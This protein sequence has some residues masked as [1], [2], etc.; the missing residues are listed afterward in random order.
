MIVCPSCGANLK[1]DPKSQK[2]LCDFCGSSFDPKEFDVKEDAQEQV[3]QEENPDTPEF[4]TIDVTIYTCPQCGGELM[5]VDENTAAAFC[6]FCG[7]STILNARLA[8][9]KKPEYIIPFAKTKEDC[10]KAYL[11]VVGK[12]LFLPKEYRSDNCIDSFR[13]I[14]MPYW[15]Y[16][17]KQKGQTKLRGETSHRRGD[18]I[19]TDI[20]TLAGKIDA[21]YD[22]LSFDASASF[23]DSMSE[24]LAPYDIKQMVPFEASY[25]SGYYADLADVDAD[26][27]KYQAEKY[28]FNASLKRIKNET[29]EFKKY[30]ITTSNEAPN[31]S[32]MADSAVPTSA[33]NGHSAMFPVWFLSYRNGDRVAYAAVNGQTGK[34]VADLPI[35]VKKYLLSS[36]IFALVIFAILNMFLVLTP[37]TAL[38][39]SSILTLIVF[40]INY[41]QRDDIRRTVTGEG[42]KGKEFLKEQGKGKKKKAEKVEE[43]ETGVFETVTTLLGVGSVAIAVLLVFFIQPVSDIPYYVMCI[44]EAVFF[45]L[46]FKHTLSNYNIMATRRL[47]Q[48]D[49]KGGD[50]RA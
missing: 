41:F 43:A 48:F 39:M 17:V 26:T 25:M 50:D 44:V 28:A 30:T 3:F 38:V 24:A 40:V 7:A 20:Y 47:P 27:Y 14:Y 5:S 23:D 29:R 12:A 8:K 11:N 34:V 49:R 1:F 4:D 16:N 19:I 15:T 36:G 21:E 13:G 6:S 42:D 32:K 18:Y 35:D 22:G 31:A 37:T 46:S 9:G 2:M 45:V 10:K 33:D